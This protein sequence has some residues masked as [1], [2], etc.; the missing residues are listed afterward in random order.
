ML[1]SQ[2]SRH[3]GGRR[4]W[5]NCTNIHM[6]VCMYVWDEKHIVAGYMF[7]CSVN[8]CVYVCVVRDVEIHKKLNRPMVKANFVATMNVFFTRLWV[9]PYSAVCC[10]VRPSAAVRGC[11]RSLRESASV[12]E[13]WEN[14]AIKSVK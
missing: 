10:C 5:Q 9:L 12:W 8:V 2:L 6:Y 4:E 14:V 7:A 1:C 13:I 3:R 11:L